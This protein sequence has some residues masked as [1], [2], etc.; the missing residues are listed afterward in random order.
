MKGKGL[1]FTHE[2]NIAYRVRDYQQLFH[3]SRLH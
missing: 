3:Q 2:L 1:V